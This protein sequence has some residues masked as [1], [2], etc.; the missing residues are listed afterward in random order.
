MSDDSESGDFADIAHHDR[1]RRRAESKKQTMRRLRARGGDKQSQRKAA[2]L[3][4]LARLHTSAAV[5]QSADS[6]ARPS[7]QSAAVQHI[8]E[9]DPHWHG[10]VYVEHPFGPDDDGNWIGMRF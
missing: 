3:Q 6:E 1:R 7:A 4:L 5:R 10:G 2:T 9:G 8:A